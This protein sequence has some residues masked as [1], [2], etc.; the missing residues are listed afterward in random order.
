MFKLPPGVSQ[1]SFILQIPETGGD[2]GDRDRRRERVSKRGGGGS[3]EGKGVKRGG[4][5]Y[6]KRGTE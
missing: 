4:G 2:L 3:G 6:W 1:N 5:R